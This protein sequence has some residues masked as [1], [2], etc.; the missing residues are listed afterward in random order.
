MAMERMGAVTFKG[1][2]QTVLGPVLKVGDR[3]PNAALVTNDWSSVELEQYSGKVR[4]ISVVPSL[5]TG[6][7]DLQTR[8]FNQEAAGI[9]PDVV[10]LTIS[11]DLPWAQKRWCGA[12]GIEEVITLSDT[13]SME[14]GDAYGT[15]IKEMRIEQRAVFV[16][17]RVGVIRYVEYVPQ[18]GQHVDYEKALEAAR[19]VYA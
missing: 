8:R 2:A 1:V 10:V 16:V 13:R 7:C 6:I 9:G 3:A 4:L 11:A 15:H 12:S 17:D 18:V 19:A 14:F 5:D